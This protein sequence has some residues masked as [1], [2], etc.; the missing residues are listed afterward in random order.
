MIGL[1]FKFRNTLMAFNLPSRLLFDKKFDLIDGKAGFNLIASKAGN[2]IFRY[3]ATIDLNYNWRPEKKLV[4][5]KVGYTDSLVTNDTLYLYLDK[6]C[7]K[8][9]NNEDGVGSYWFDIVPEIPWIKMP[10]Q[11][12]N[13]T[14]GLN[15]MLFWKKFWSL[16]FTLFLDG[17]IFTQRTSWYTI[18]TISNLRDGP[19][20]L[21]VLLYEK[22][23]GKY[24]T[25]IPIGSPKYYGGSTPVNEFKLNEKK[26]FDGTVSAQMIL[27]RFGS[28]YGN[29]TVML[30]GSQTFS[31]LHRYRIPIPVPKYS[32]GITGDYKPIHHIRKPKN[33][34]KFN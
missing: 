13:A 5:I 33:R 23:S 34:A 31:S 8:K 19:S 17:K 1:P 18:D 24:Y 16:G 26:R 29:F 21:F 9:F 20:G 22:K 30:W 6:E 14:L 3:G 27:Q 11:K 7:T 12:V 25:D 2:G 10:E 32:W 4:S 15:S 28:H